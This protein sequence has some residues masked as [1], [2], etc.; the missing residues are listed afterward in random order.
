[1]SKILIVDDDKMICK[2]LARYIQ[3][4]GHECASVLTLEDGLKEVLSD[5]FDGILLQ[6]SLLSQERVIRMARSLP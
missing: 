4:M 3:R 1:M 6:K 2:T 5:T